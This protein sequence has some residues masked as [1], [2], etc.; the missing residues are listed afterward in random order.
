[1][2]NKI[3]YDH[4]SDGLTENGNRSSERTDKL[5]NGILNYIKNIIPNFDDKYNVFHEKPILCTYGNK[6]K[7][8]I[9]IEDKKGNIVCCILLKAFISSVQ[10]NRANNAN[11]T[12]GEIFR[13]KGVPGREN[14][15][16][17]FISFISNETPSYK[18]DGT[19]RTME[20]VETSYVD[21]SKLENR[22]NIYHSTI[23]YDLQNVIYSTK[24]DFK[25]TLLIEN[26]KNI[27]ENTLIENAKRIF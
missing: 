13:I 10:K 3:I 5:H 6:F 14:V 25:N 24:I 7:I 27:T 12:Q 8:D 9:L 4:I 26:I 2:L 11:T 16:V 15:K 1:M 18:N 21:L 19:L 22:P 20:K 17:W 23:K